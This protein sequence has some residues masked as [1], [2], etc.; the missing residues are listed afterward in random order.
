[1]QPASSGAVGKLDSI[2]EQ[3]GTNQPGTFLEAQAI[4]ENIRIK[5]G[6]LGQDFLKDIEQ[7]RS[8]HQNYIL[9]SLEDKRATEAAYTTR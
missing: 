8:E 2:L 7:L 3:L 1:M 4:V 9:Q 5:K 6:Y